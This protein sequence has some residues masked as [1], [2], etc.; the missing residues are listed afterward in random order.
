MALENN[1]FIM[2]LL[3]KDYNMDTE[4]NTFIIDNTHKTPVRNID[5]CLLGIPK[6]LYINHEIDPSCLTEIQLRDQ[7]IQIGGIVNLQHEHHH[8][9][10]IKSNSINENVT[11]LYEI[12]KIFNIDKNTDKSKIESQEK[13]F[14]DILLI[15]SL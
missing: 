7:L 8:I 4:N 13:I 1:Q 6:R 15:N 2:T 9:F 3:N 14:R 10:N 12:L 5:A 11:D